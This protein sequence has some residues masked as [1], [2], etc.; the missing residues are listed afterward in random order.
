MRWLVR[1]LVIA[2]VAATLMI[3]TA[4]LAAGGA[5]AHA[6]RL[7]PHPIPCAPAPCQ[8]PGS[9][10]KTGP[11][12]ASLLA[13]STVVHLSISPHVVQADQLITMKVS[14]SGTGHCDP[15][16][17]T[18]GPGFSGATLADPGTEQTLGFIPVS[19]GRPNPNRP[20]KISPG[21]TTQCYEVSETDAH[22]Y[23]GIYTIVSAPAGNCNP[24]DCVSEDWLQVVPS[25]TGLCPLNV[26]IK[27]FGSG[28]AGLGY[29]R[30]QSPAV[31]EFL[32][33]DTSGLGEGKCLS[34]CTNVQVT[35]TDQRDGQ[36]VAGAQVEAFV[37]PFAR[38]AI[39]PYPGGF[40]SDDG[41]LCRA[42]E[43]DRCGT[44][45]SDLPAT[46]ANGQVRFFYWAPGAIDRQTIRLK[47]NA[48]KACSTCE[49][50]RQTGSQLADIAVSPNV[51]YTHDGTLDH[52]ALDVLETWATHDANFATIGDQLR[53]ATAEHALSSAIKAIAEFYAERAV[54]VLLAAEALHKV[55]TTPGEYADLSTTLGQE[56]A[57]TALFLNPL[58]LATA[59]LGAVD[60][61]ELD[62]R[63][64][65]FIAGKHGLLRRL[66]ETSDKLRSRVPILTEVMHLRV[67]E[68]SYCKQGEKC[69][70]GD[71]TPGVE[72]FLYFD[73]KVDAPASRFAGEQ[74]V[75][76]EQFV[77]P[78]DA[79]Y[80]DLL[81]FNGKGPPR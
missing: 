49:H 50:G 72:P 9:P 14:Y 56:E 20:I 42:D 15:K 77:L 30:S 39:A 2:L 68:V 74:K 26:S 57:L 8:Q 18:C 67:V 59:G 63:F 32:G 43:P 38:G 13:Q 69:G 7:G 45:L 40:E 65:E 61:G 78:Y 36:P 53:N 3:P 44:D 28:T 81:Q 25:C 71:S 60:A 5:R 11:G 51:I 55:L 48:Q 12:G 1:V 19:C 6:A 29:D 34:G 17:S 21:A 47:V 33:P 76:D 52:E 41:H 35:V 4:A 75:L 58:G 31:P 37:R 80:F 27:T 64:L 54:P 70:P 23:F 62:P 16:M 79:E 10:V 66:G 22:F 73:F 24:A 46:D